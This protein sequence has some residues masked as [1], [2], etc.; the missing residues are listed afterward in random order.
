[1]F[2]FIALFGPDGDDVPEGWIPSRVQNLL[3]AD[4]CI[5]VADD[6]TL[7]IEL[8]GQHFPLRLDY[9]ITGTVRRRG[10]YRITCHD[11]DE[12]LLEER[13]PEDAKSP[14]LALG[15][16]SDHQAPFH[17]SIGRASRTRRAQIPPDL[18]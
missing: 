4:L 3:D 17:V 5:E 6:G 14:K 8:D 2:D 9:E 13:D 1:M 10:K 7:K 15:A 11:L 16:P 12:Y 18:V